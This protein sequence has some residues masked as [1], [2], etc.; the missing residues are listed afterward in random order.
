MSNFEYDSDDIDDDNNA[1]IVYESEEPNLTRFNISICELYNSKIHGPPISLDVL[2]HYLVRVRYKKLDIEYINDDARYIQHEYTNMINTN[3]DIFKNYRKIIKNKNYIKPEIIECIYLDTGYCVAIL[4]TYW[5]KI[6]QR[7]W[8]NILKKR[9]KIIN[10]RHH[11]F[12]LRH[13]EI[14]G[15]WSENCRYL[16]RLKGM[17]SKIVI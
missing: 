15:E 8:K 3:H 2:C 10:L 6:I 4:K 13:R 14:T 1:D 9:E 16:P 11:P 5:I 12:S 17:L 7:I